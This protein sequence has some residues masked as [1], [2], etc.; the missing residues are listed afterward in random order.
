[1]DR[2]LDENALRHVL[3][4]HPAPAV[5]FVD[6]WTG[7]GV[8][9]AELARAVIGFNQRQGTRLDPGLF[10]VADLCGAAACA[11]TTADYLIPSSILGATVSG[12]VSRSILNEQAVSPGDF[13]GCLY[14]NEFESHDLSRWF[15]DRLSAAIERRVRAGAWPATVPGAAE[16]AEARRR[17]DAFLSEVRRRFGVRH[18]RHVK[19]GLGEATRV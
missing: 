17:S 3:D 18:V 9:A 10:A 19:P 1:R 5:V 7:K 6:G 2:G 14:Y 4:R 15:A 16:L 11:A 12:L 8:I 13:H